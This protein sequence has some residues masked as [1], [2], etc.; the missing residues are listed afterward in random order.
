MLHTLWVEEIQVSSAHSIRDDSRYDAPLKKTTNQAQLKKV[1]RPLQCLAF[2][3]MG[4][5]FF[6]AQS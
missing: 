2:F 3:S 5:Q 4:L 6:N 1:Q